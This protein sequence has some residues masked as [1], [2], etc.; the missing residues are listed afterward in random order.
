MYYSKRSW[1]LIKNLVLAILV[2]LFCAPILGAQNNAQE[3]RMQFMVGSGLLINAIPTQN[4]ADINLQGVV[5]KIPLKVY[6]TLDLQLQAEFLYRFKTWFHAGAS[7]QQSFILMPSV[8][9][10]DNL[11]RSS[12]TNDYTA[13]YYMI[14]NI[15]LSSF[16]PKIAI[17]LLPKAT[18]E[19]LFLEAGLNVNYV[20][21][22]TDFLTETDGPDSEWDNFVGSGAETYKRNGWNLGWQMG[23]R[24]VDYF[25][26]HWGY[27]LYFTYQPYTFKPTHMQLTKYT[28]N[29]QDL[30]STLNARQREYNF[31]N[32]EADNPTNPNAPTE[33]AE[34]SYS[35]R[36]FILGI[37]VNYR[38]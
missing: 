34:E 36:T 29:G 6:E 16:I 23:A 1:L 22:K 11:R 25:S 24:W 37:S 14:S 26:E 3:P 28:L 30:T 38:F 7:F 17:D 12:S 35:F 19:H 13:N 9:I 10:E 21:F 31:G 32:P 5:P 4:S 27:S 15:R 20:F 33:L 2:A 8:A 18:D